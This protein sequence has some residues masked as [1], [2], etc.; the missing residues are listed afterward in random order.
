MMPICPHRNVTWRSVICGSAVQSIVCSLF[1]ACSLLA[2][3]IISSKTGTLQSAKQRAISWTHLHYNNS[4]LI[5]L[6]RRLPLKNTFDHVLHTRYAGSR[7]N[8]TY[9]HTSAYGNT[10]RAYSVVPFMCR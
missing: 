9:E 6:N 5:C 1:N 3:C 10:T 7:N 4:L 8:G 2:G